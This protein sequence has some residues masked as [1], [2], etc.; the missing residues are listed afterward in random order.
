MKE[1]KQEIQIEFQFDNLIGI[2]IL[3]NRLVWRLVADNGDKYIELIG[4]Q[5]E[6]LLQSHKLLAER[7]LALMHNHDCELI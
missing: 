1:N 3:H 6:Q 5:L 2:R 7:L 4:V